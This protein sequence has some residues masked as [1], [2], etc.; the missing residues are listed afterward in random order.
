M[1]KNYCNNCKYYQKYYIKGKQ[2]FFYAFAGQ[3]YKKQMV[4]ANGGACEDWQERPPVDKTVRK[5]EVYQAI[6]KAM[7][8]L[9]Q[10]QQIVKEI[11][12]D[13]FS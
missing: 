10:L 4:I 7:N 1:K 3:C 11:E 12:K 2:C 5:Q 13:K 9:K 6:V 8:G